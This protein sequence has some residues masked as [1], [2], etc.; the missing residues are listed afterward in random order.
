MLLDTVY[1]APSNTALVI[2]IIVIKAFIIADKAHLFK[3][4]NVIPD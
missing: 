1:S 3:V 4:C 2:C